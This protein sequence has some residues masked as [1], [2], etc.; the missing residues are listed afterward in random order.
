MAVNISAR[1]LQEGDF[2]RRI[3]TILKETNLDPS[4]VELELTESA[5]I[6]G[7]D[8]SPAVLEELSAS[9]LRMAI[10]DFGTGYSSVNYLRQFKFD[11]LKLDRCFVQDVVTNRKTAA[12]AKGVITLAHNLDMS[13]VAEGVENEA[14]LFFL[15]SHS[16]DQAQGYLISKALPPEQLVEFIRLGAVRPIHDRSGS[17]RAGDLHRLAGYAGAQE[18]RVES[19][20]PLGD[21]YRPLAL[22][23]TRPQNTP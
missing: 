6:N 3:M 22:N 14:Q 16:C 5:L 2:P 17:Q 23:A 12:I 9:G 20:S 19:A 18:I 13:V 21:P 10:D 7:L 1:Q 15:A 4:M 11:T 8:N